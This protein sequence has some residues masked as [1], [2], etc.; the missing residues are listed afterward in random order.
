M[1]EY[2]SARLGKV[3]ACDRAASCWNCGHVL[4]AAS[5]TRASTTR[6]PSRSSSP[7]QASAASLLSVCRPSP[8][9]GGCRIRPTVSPSRRGSGTGRLASTDQS[10]ATSATDRPIGPDGSL[11]RSDK[12]STQR[13]QQR[14]VR[15]LQQERKARRPAV[16]PSAASGAL[17]VSLSINPRDRSGRARPRVRTANG[18]VGTKCEPSGATWH[19]RPAS[20]R[21]ACS[22]R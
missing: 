5:G 4:A 11:E 7:T 6:P 19:P 18:E 1:S 17:S 12:R 8:I 10:S 20:D 2:S 13:E 14:R 15:E 21:L 9:S 22:A 3:A 16:L